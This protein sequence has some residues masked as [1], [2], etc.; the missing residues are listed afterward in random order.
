MNDKEKGSKTLTAG[1][2]LIKLS[3]FVTDSGNNKLE[4]LSLAKFSS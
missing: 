2:N 4:R 1:V 3:L